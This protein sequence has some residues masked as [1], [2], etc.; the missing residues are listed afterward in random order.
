MLCQ[1]AG[2]TKWL[3]AKWQKKGKE[4]AI[5]TH[6]ISGLFKSPCWQC[7]VDSLTSNDARSAQLLHKKLARSVAKSRVADIC[8]A[9]AAQPHSISLKVY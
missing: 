7:Q 9:I 6:V 1:A 5:L 2:V 3:V 8:I 4:S